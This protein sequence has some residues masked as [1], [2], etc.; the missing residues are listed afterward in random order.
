MQRLRLGDPLPFVAVSLWA[1][2]GAALLASSCQQAAR[3]NRVTPAVALKATP[4]GLE[5]VRVTEGPFLEAAKQNAEYLREL[6]PDRL[7]HNFRKFSGLDP[8]GE[9]YGGWESLGLAGHTLGHYLSALSMQYASTG[10]D[11]YLQ[12]VNYIVT[13]LGAVAQA[14]GDG[15]IGGMPGGEQVFE[16][17]S[18]GEIETE[19]FALNDLWAPW[20]TLHKI[21]AGLLEAHELCGNEEALGLAAGL[22]DWS[23]ET[24]KDLSDELWQKMLLCEYGG[25]NEALAN[26]YAVTGVQRY[27]DLSRR[28][29]DR[30]FLAPVM[31]NQDR[32][33]GYHGNTQIPK[34]IGLGRQYE[35]LGEQS[36][37]STVEY[38]WERVVSHH[39]YVTGGHGEDEYWGPPDQLADR[40]GVTA[41][42][43]CNTYNM[44]KLTRRLFSW[45][46]DPQYADF[47]E[48]ALYNH[49][50]GSIDPETGRTT[51]FLSLKP[52]HFKTYCTRENSFWCCTGSGFENHVKYNDSIYFHDGGKDLY[53]NLFI[54]SEVDWR[55]AGMT[56]SQETRFPEEGA[57]RLKISTSRPT[58]AAL[59]IRHPAW[60]QGPL[61]LEINGDAIEANSVPG[62]YATVSRTWSDGD[63]VDVGFSMRLSLEAVPGGDS[64]FAILY[65]PIVLAGDLGGEGLAEPI[66]YA[67][68][69]QAYGA[70]PAPRVPDLVAQPDRVESWVQPVSSQPLTFRTVDVGRP[71][72]VSLVPLYRVHHRRYN[73]YWNLYD[74][75]AWRQADAAYRDAERNR[76]QLEAAT[77]DRVVLG[78]DDDEKAHGLQSQAAASSS[79]DFR[80]RTWRDAS[81]SG[82]FSVRLKVAGAQPVKLVTMRSAA[83]NK[84]NRTTNLGFDILVEGQRVGGEDDLNPSPLDEY[85]D[86][87]LTS[88]SIPAD[89]VRGEKELE[90]RFQARAGRETGSIYEL[91]T[92]ND[93]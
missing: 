1:A 77:V 83:P 33:D 55:D 61:R 3:A 9:L 93:R 37:R 85:D 62:G 58:E 53:V 79:Y 56:V 45:T 29:Q 63:T 8:K 70:V 25:M 68:E 50:L 78:D 51:Y 34:L 14:R 66:P 17:V 6:E 27:L 64:R 52:G 13:E 60:S 69:Q 48:R 11:L 38:F 12:R 42:E 90:V 76:R 35:L 59:H 41:Q 65:G 57:T 80:G 2:V 46:A 54:P 5:D 89:L 4:F 16:M 30:D 15:Y 91:R 21:M 44:L 47:Y 10:D 24:T 39:S 20:Y 74:G 72:D 28:F 31:R 23:Y 22:A 18:R 82:W 7:L 81:D 67:A 43:T 40:L 92:V 49:I 86:Y 19:R 75:Q 26:L 84:W 88:Y 36:L 71:D 32:L 73:V 87:Y